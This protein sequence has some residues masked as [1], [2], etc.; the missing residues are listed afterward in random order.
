LHSMTKL[1][2]WLR[3]WAGSHLMSWEKRQKWDRPLISHRHL[4]L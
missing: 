2:G 4:Y 3:Y 1:S